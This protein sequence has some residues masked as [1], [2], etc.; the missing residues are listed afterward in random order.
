MPARLDDAY[1]LTK[2]S[3]SV[4]LAQVNDP[5]AP[6]VEMTYLTP[7][8]TKFCTLAAATAA[9]ARPPQVSLPQ[10]PVANA[11]V[12]S[13]SLAG[14]TLSSGDSVPDTAVEMTL[15]FQFMLTVMSLYG[16]NTTVPVDGVGAGGV[17]VGAGGV[18]VGAGGVGVGAG[19]VAEQPLDSVYGWPEPAP[20]LLVT[21]SLPCV[22]QLAV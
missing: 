20:P 3:K 19:G 12:I 7:A 9:G 6:P 5:A 22:H 14:L 8:L 16:L 11:Q 18:G 10:A 2:V 13:L 21:G 4:S 17:G 1:R 15:V